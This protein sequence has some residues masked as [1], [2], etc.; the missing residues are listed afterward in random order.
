MMV[1]EEMLNLSPM[2]EGTTLL[3]ETVAHLHELEP[4]QFIVP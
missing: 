2:T 4:S 3:F 1:E